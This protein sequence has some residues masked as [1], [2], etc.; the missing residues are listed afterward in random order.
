VFIMQCT[1]CGRELASD[2]TFCSNCGVAVKN[3]AMPEGVN[4]VTGVPIET[5]TEVATPTVVEPVTMAEPVV[6]QTTLTPPV[7]APIN[8]EPVNVV[9]QPTPVHVEEPAHVENAVTTETKVEENKGNPAVAQVMGTEFAAKQEDDNVIPSGG[10]NYGP[11]PIVDPPAL[12]VAVPLPDAPAAPKKKGFPVAAIVAVLVVAFVGVLGLGILA[13]SILLAPKQIEPEKILPTE[14]REKVTFGGA[15]FNI[16]TD[17]Y[18]YELSSGKLAIFNNDIYFYIMIAPMS[19]N[20]YSSNIPYLKSYY[21][22]EGYNVTDGT[23]KRVGEQR[24]VIL[25]ME[26]ASG[27]VTLFI[28][29]FNASNSLTGAIAKT[30]GEYA[31]EEDLRLVESILGTNKQI[32]KS[33]TGD[34]IITIDNEILNGIIEYTGEEPIE[35]QVPD[36]VEE[37]TNVKVTE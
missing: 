25:N 30:T 9:V 17:N 23:E 37:D 33:T 36:K 16:P 34:K 5:A 4:T 11:A 3:V 1:N 7:E 19:Y 22:S 28:R 15:T 35:E 2:D 24:Y 26:N 31:S 29:P 10:V 13:G 14:T 8:S 32:E 6:Q 12:G 18:E 21:G 20:Q 27:K